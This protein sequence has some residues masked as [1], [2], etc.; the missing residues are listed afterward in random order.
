MKFI[1][2]LILLSFAGVAFASGGMSFGTVEKHMGKPTLTKSSSVVIDAARL[3]HGPIDHFQVG[4]NIPAIADI[5]N[6]GKGTDSS[7]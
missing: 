5:E 4:D 3:A 7:I 1:T 6:K 2:V